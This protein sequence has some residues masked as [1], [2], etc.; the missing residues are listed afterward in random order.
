MFVGDKHVRWWEIVFLCPHHWPLALLRFIYRSSGLAGLALEDG[1]KVLNENG[2][3]A[4]IPFIE[5]SNSVAGGTGQMFQGRARPGLVH[6]GA[7]PGRV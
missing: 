3:V 4:F 5:L 2:L 6:D 1:I 7:Q